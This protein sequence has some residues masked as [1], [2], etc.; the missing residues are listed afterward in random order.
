MSV[1]L[2]SLLAG[3]RDEAVTAHIESTRF[4]PLALHAEHQV[5][6]LVA[7]IVHEA[8]NCCNSGQFPGR[9]G[10]QHEVRTKQQEKVLMLA[11]KM[12]EAGAD[13]NQTAPA[14]SSSSVQVQQIAQDHWD[15]ELMDRD[16]EDDEADRLTF[17][18]EEDYRFMH[19]FKEVVRCAGHSAMSLAAAVYQQL[20]SST[21]TRSSREEFVD[22]KYW[23]F[24][25]GYDGP[26]VESVWKETLEIFDALLRYFD[27]AARHAP[28]P[29]RVRVAESVVA[30]WEAFL[31]DSQSH[32]VT[33]ICSG[34]EAVTAHARMLELSS[35]VLAT[36]LSSPL[37]EGQSKSI[38]LPDCPA[39]TQHVETALALCQAASVWPPS[40][41][42]SQRPRGQITIATSVLH[43]PRLRRGSLSTCCT[44]AAARLTSM[45]M[46]HCS[47]RYGSRTAGTCGLWSTCSSA[48]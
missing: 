14:T 9:G 21:A 3:H 48:S 15:G 29:E 47:T 10:R 5:P 26:A 1:E 46:P 4:S 18:R 33:L 16:S 36:M 27:E 32:D 35:P 11:R 19:D 12:V 42:C 13:P 37:L 45:R 8:T 22:D 6:P 23:E 39:A 17:Q 40:L 44:Q 28:E 31:Q 38:P 43:S 7:L 2:W 30:R 24:N 25:N 20:S 41:I 34:D